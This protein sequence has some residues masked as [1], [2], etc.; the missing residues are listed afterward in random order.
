MPVHLLDR[1]MDQAGELVLSR[2]QLL[3]NMSATTDPIIK[4]ILQD[5]DTLQMTDAGGGF[6]AGGGDSTPELHFPVAALSDDGRHFAGLTDDGAVYVRVD[7][8]QGS[9]Q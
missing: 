9:Y 5:L 1:L 3:S 8:E 4:G 2:N 6:I 7:G